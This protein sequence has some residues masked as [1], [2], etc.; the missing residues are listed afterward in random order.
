MKALK[1]GTAV[2]AI[3]AAFARPVNADVI[4]DWN[5]KACGI[6]A[7]FTGPAP[8]GHRM[9]AIVQVAVFE[10]VNS[11]EPRYAPYLERIP[12]PP[13]ASIP[14]AVAA[15]NRATLL[16]LMP[17]EKG[18][19]EG[20]YQSALAA[21]SD[22]ASRSDGIAV[23][24]R[25][26]AMILTRAANDGSNTPDMYQ[27]YTAPGRYVPTML[28]H[29]W[30]WTR[31]VPWIVAKPSQFRPGPPPALDSDTWRNDFQEVKTVGGRD[32]TAR[33]SAQTAIG[34]FWVEGGPVIYHPVMRSVANMP[35]RT[36]AQNARLFAAGSVAMDDGMIAVFDAKYAYNF[37]RPITAIRND[38]VLAK[39]KVPA[40][41]TWMPLIT[42][43]LHPEYPC[44]HCVASAALGA[45][46]KAELADAPTPRLS[47]S[48]PTAN[49]AVREWASISD[50]TH[51]VRMARIYDGVHYRN[52]TIVGSDIGVK[53]G[54]LVGAKFA[55]PARAGQ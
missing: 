9:M 8:G 5:E 12:A 30:T 40:D 2:I 52:S 11:I 36:V 15:A 19:I 18:A 46:L 16:E 4:T 53:V 14:A 22:G 37:W 38:Q 33:T 35:G 21:I 13:G 25:A 32:S 45:V 54:D 26:A 6:V 39:T 10:A 43:P 7:R 17:G 28:P 23:G 42:T 20:V 51:E 27:P 1:L 49:N 44:A 50:F 55:P 3:V 29:S 41:L 47:S 34:R 31:R 24:E 48:S